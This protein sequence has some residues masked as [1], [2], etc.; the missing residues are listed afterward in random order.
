M[1]LSRSRE[2]RSSAFN[3]PTRERSSFSAAEYPSF[4]TEASSVRLEQG[5]L[6]PPQANI[7]ESEIK[8]AAHVAKL[9]FDSNLAGVVDPA[10]YEAFIRSHVYK[11]EYRRR[12]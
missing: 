1:R 4:W 7:L 6:F 5:L 3:R 10:D 8:V 12:V 2:S 11:P 9:V